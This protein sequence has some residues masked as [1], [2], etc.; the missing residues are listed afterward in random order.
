[1]TKAQIIAQI[2][3]KFHGEVE[4]VLAERPEATVKVRPEAIVKV[5]R[6]VKET[7]ELSFSQLLFLTAMDYPDRT[8]MVYYLASMK[9]GHKAVLRVILPRESPR[10]SSVTPVW[11]GADWHEREAADFFG[12]TFEGHPDPRRILLPEDWSWSPPLRKDFECPEMVRK[13]EIK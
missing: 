11:A 7:P 6:F 13:P 2:C 10:V 3:E 9:H 8:E 5:C 12:I 1:M 4:E